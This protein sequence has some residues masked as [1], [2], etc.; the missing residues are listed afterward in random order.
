MPLA[1]RIALRIA[2]FLALLPLCAQ[3]RQ[4]PVPVKAAVEEFLQV[5][6]RGLPGTPSFH[7]NSIDAANNLP[8]CEAF[9]PFLPAGARLWGRTTV[10]VR[11]AAGANWSLFVKVQVKVEGDY[12]VAAHA[13]AQGQVLTAADLGRQH[14]D[15][16]EQPAGVLVEPEQAIGRTVTLG[17]SAGRPLRS[18]MLRQVQAVLQGQSVKVLSGGKNFQVSTEGRALNAAAAGQVVQVRLASGQVLSGIAR[19][20]GVVEISY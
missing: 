9:E 2:C 8:S 6:T 19:P 18:D 14:G 15:L 3:A 12:L 20:G 13:L 16:T 1:L 7:V 11:C 10:G 17:L 5:Q 4:D